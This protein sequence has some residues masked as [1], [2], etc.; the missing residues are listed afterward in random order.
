MVICII[1]VM[2]LLF[3]LWEAL[4]GSVDP[5]RVA[6]YSLIFQVVDKILQ[7]LDKLRRNNRRKPSEDIEDDE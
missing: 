2:I 6:I 5:A 4:V 1:Y 7:I 3:L